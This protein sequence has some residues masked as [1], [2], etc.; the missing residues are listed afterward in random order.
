MSP[1]G[2]LDE[3][4]TVNAIDDR[5]DPENVSS[6]A[7]FPDD[8]NVMYVHKT[9]KEDVESEEGESLIGRGKGK[10]RQQRRRTPA[11]Q[12]NGFRR[13]LKDNLAAVCMTA[14]L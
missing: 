6:A 14:H 2:S 4:D 13:L 3:E 8:N 9:D 11:S 5:T 1:I 10:R 12:A 7:V